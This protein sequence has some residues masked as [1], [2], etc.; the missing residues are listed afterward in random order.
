MNVL[1]RGCQRQF[2]LSFLLFHQSKYYTGAIKLFVSID[3][4]YKGPNWQSTMAQWWNT[5][6]L[7]L[8]NGK[9]FKIT[10]VI[11]HQIGDR[12]LQIVKC[13]QIALHLYLLAMNPNTDKPK[14]IQIRPNINKY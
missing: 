12:I 13:N 10:L 2:F 3:K 1:F 7:I 11:A 5:H 6:L 8:G 9:W 14:D 4:I